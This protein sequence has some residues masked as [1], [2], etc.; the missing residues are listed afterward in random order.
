MLSKLSKL[1]GRR[2]PQQPHRAGTVRTSRRFVPQ[3]EMLETRVVL[4]PILCD[5][6]FSFP[7]GTHTYKI[8]YCHNYRLDVPNP[9]VTRVVLAVHGIEREAV[10]T[11]NDVLTA[12]QAA[13]ADS[14][15]LLIAPQF[16]DE[17]DIVAYTL[18]NDYMY[19]NGPW[20]D[21]AQSSSTSAHRRPDKVSSFEVVD[22]LLTRVADSGNF[23]NLNT[24]IV[25]GHSAG[26]QFI[27][28]YAA[29]FHSDVE[30]HL[31]GDLGLSIRYV[32][33]N[34][35]TYLYLD[36]ARWDSGSGTFNI[37][38]GTDGYNN[39]PYG[40]ENVSTT[41]YPY[42]TDVDRNPDTFPTTIRAQYARRQVISIL[43]ENDTSRADPLDKTPPADLQGA[44]RFE[45]G[46]IFFN[47]LSYLQDS[48]QLDILSHQFRETVPGVG[49]DST[50]MYASSPAL[51]W[52]FDFNGPASPSGNPGSELPN[53]GTGSSS[54]DLSSANQSLASL[55]VHGGGTDTPVFFD[56]AYPDTQT[57]HFDA[58]PSSLTLTA[59]PV[60]VSFTDMASVFRE[61][62]GH[63]TMN[64]LSGAVLVDMP[65]PV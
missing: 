2:R 54:F 31:S 38:T 52:L 17:S 33:M 28:H 11:Y 10:S 22:D 41:Q 18:P 16:L 61:T 9:D 24:V 63:S 58:A 27:Q 65:P 59:V 26:G 3:F 50:A 35:G 44:N 46:S 36:P 1:F 39:Y 14:S 53:V 7:V 64:D 8:P 5:D 49:H 43:G 51:K 56:T 21:G 37:P 6:Q 57:Y 15:S 60:S 62:K 32:T 30:N 19:W 55:T 20:R 48:Y 29:S 40:L 42:V 12:A 4:S 13:G 25:S 34:P 45:R 23:P 47:Y